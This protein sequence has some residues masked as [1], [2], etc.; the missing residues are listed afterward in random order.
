LRG[1]GGI[2]LGLCGDVGILDNRIEANGTNAVNPTCGIF[3]QYGEGVDIRRNH[4]LDNGPLPAQRADLELVPGHR[5]GI[6]LNL[7]GSLNLLAGAADKTQAA[8]SK[9]RPAARV[10]ENVVD[11]PAGRALHISG[12]GALMCTDNSFASE[13]SGPTDLERQAGTVFIYNLGGTQKAPPGIRV[14]AGAGLAPAQPIAVQPHIDFTRA[15]AAILLL[16]D[17]NTLFNDNQSRTGAAN[18]SASCQVIS[19]L[20]DL[21]YHANQSQSDRAGNLVSNVHLNANTLR[22]IGNR[23]I[24]VGPETQMSLFTLAVRMNDTS[25]NQ[26]DHCIIATDQNP[27][28][29]EVRTGNQVLNPSPRC[30]DRLVIATSLFKPQ[31]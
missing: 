31:G 26:G 4:V 1:I 15:A 16:P 12:I 18:Q 9:P 20:G 13:L 7:V 21:A 24:E 3:V 30:A 6:V 14:S 5:G 22:A 29:A 28:M 2:S 19:C 27:A 25:L 8:S 17:G 23:F 11:Q 10:H